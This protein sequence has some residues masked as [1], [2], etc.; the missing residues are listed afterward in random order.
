MHLPI[1]K[2]FSISGLGKHFLKG[3]LTKKQTSQ[4]LFYTYDPFKKWFPN[5]KIENFPLMH[6]RIYKKKFFSEVS[7]RY[8]NYFHFVSKSRNGR[9][10]PTHMG[11]PQAKNILPNQP[12]PWMD[13]T[14]KVSSKSEILAF[15]LTFVPC[16]EA[17]LKAG[18]YMI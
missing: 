2:K 1:Y 5:P 15:R 12:Y 14:S 7:E 16:V 18:I 11:W 13:E 9:G 4:N 3:S 8:L 17:L 10:C 6:L